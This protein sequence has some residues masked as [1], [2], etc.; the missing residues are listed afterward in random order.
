MARGRLSVPELMGRLEDMAR[1]TL[2]YAADV[3]RSGAWIAPSGRRALLAWD[4]ETA[5]ADPLVQ[6]AEDGLSAQARGGAGYM[7]VSCDASAIEVDDRQASLTA[8][9]RIGRLAPV[10][11]TRT[12]DAWLV[13]NRA[14]LLA[15]LCTPDGLPRYELPA[16]VP[17]VTD[18][19]LRHD[20]TPYADVDLLGPDGSLSVSGDAIR[21]TVPDPAGLRCGSVVPSETDLEDLGQRLCKAVVASASGDVVCDVTGGRD[22]RLIAATLKAAGVAFRARTRGAPHDPDV[23]VGAQVARALGVPHERVTAPTVAG[24]DGDLLEVDVAARTRATLYATDGMLFAWENVGGMVH[25]PGDGTRYGGSGGETLRGGFAKLVSRDLRPTWDAAADYLH[26]R[27]HRFGRLFR[28]GATDE[29]AS[30]L[31]AWVDTERAAGV[32]AGV[33]LE[34]YYVWYRTGRWKA[35]FL[36]AGNLDAPRHPLLD[37]PITRFGLRL[38]P[39]AKADDR[40][41]QELTVRLAPSLRDVPYANRLRGRTRI[42]D[43]PSTEET[44]AMPFDWRR[45]TTDQMYPA[46]RDQVLGGPGSAQLASLVDRDRLARWMERRAETPSADLGRV[47]MFM[48]GLYS[49]SVLLSDEWLEPA[50]G[51]PRPVRIRVPPGSGTL[52]AG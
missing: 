33:S 4:N 23:V 12:N 44:V 37:D 34:R 27:L 8:S 2:P 5:L 41:A 9:T 17:L 39:A 29:Y 25:S 6:V 49:C 1:V 20:R 35:A 3:Y 18:G 14:L 47:A 51:A 19:Y 15:R 28:P 50:R 38:A 46:F 45:T 30:G 24:P 26:S 10:Y 36:A 31:Q 13:S 21:V 42:E 43:G 48:W 7:V 52:A 32:P 22:S 40:L 11:W 16:L